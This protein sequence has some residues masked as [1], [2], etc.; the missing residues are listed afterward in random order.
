MAKNRKP[1]LNMAN[2]LHCANSAS[3]VP[4]LQLTSSSQVASLSG[5]GP[6]AIVDRRHFGVGMRLSV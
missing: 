2:T 1:R 6:I 4:A 5:I 3:S